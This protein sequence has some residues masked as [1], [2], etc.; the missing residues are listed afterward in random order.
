MGF[1]SGEKYRPLN[2]EESDRLCRQN[3]EESSSTSSDPNYTPGKEAFFAGK[4]AFVATNL[5]VF[6]FSLLL[7]LSSRSVG[8]HEGGRNYL[9]K[10]TSSYC[11]SLLNTNSI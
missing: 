9:L 7:F 6:V 3:S 1:W 2:D 8:G 10:Q 11:M 4:K 5:A